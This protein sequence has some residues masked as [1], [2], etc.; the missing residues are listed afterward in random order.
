VTGKADQLLQTVSA[1][2]R[3]GIPARRDG[4][5]FK[6]PRYQRD[7]GDACVAFTVGMTYQVSDTDIRRREMRRNILRHALLSFLFGAVIL[8]ASVNVVA[9][10]SNT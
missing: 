10:F 3:S 7:Y 8:A 5:D 6:E 2:R 4:V 9:G 1:G